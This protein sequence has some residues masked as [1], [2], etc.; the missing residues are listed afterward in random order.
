[1]KNEQDEEEK[2]KREEEDKKTKEESDDGNYCLF[3]YTIDIRSVLYTLL[4]GRL[5]Q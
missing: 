3:L 4:P 2:K 1:M 5:V